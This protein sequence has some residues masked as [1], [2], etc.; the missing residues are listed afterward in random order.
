MNTD[1]TRAQVRAL[2]LVA[3][4]SPQKSGHPYADLLDAAADP[5]TPLAELASIK[6]TAKGHLER[7]A[8]ARQR[9][10]AALVYHTAVAAAFVHHRAR[11]SGRPMRKQREI[12][13]QFADAHGPGP[14]GRVFREALVRMAEDP[15]R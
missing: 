15:E 1:L 13:Q 11:I 7:A 12:Y 6:D 14:L 8:D 5:S 3:A 9:E 2:L 10:Q 4:K